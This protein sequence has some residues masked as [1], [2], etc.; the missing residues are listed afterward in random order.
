VLLLVVTWILLY[1]SN[2]KTLLLVKYWIIISKSVLCFPM[3]KIN[4][5]RTCVTLC[6]LV[7]MHV[8]WWSQG[9]ILDSHSEGAGFWYPVTFVCRF[10]WLQTKAVTS[11]RE[12]KYT[13]MRYEVLMVVKMLMLVFWVVMPLR[14]LKDGG[15]IY[16]WNIDVYLQDNMASQ[17]R[18]STLKYTC[19][20]TVEWFGTHIKLLVPSAGH[21]PLWSSYHQE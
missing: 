4:A 10:F 14:C 16:L 2:F 1:I 21:H 17:S 19:P 11:V 5:P 20:H 9:N 12:K 18:R 8:I 13:C 15:S 7:Q 3:V 6:L